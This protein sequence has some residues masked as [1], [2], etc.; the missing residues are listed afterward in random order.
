MARIRSIGT[1]PELAVRRAAHAM[2]LRYRLNRRDLPGTPD[3]VFPRFRVALF[4]HGCFW[5]RH[6]G[7]RLAATPKTRI[8]FW[9]AKFAGNTA[10]DARQEQALVDAGWRPVVIWEC[11]TADPARLATIIRG[12][13]MP[14]VEPEPVR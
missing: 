4:V 2:G 3:L 7:C 10:R 12:R 5:H 1:A 8:E 13:V 9:Q 11:E 6:A 14:A